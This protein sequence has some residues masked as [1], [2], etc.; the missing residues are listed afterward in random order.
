ME[1]DEGAFGK[2]KYGRSRLVKTQWV[3]GG[4]DIQTKK[5]FLVGVKKR[6]AVTLLPIIANHVLPGHL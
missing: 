4:I 3:F 5:C 2:R 1:I 6:N